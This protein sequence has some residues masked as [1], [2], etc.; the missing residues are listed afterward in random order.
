M[1]HTTNP[2][3]FEAVIF[4]FD[5]TLV[6]SLGLWRAI[7][8]IYLGARGIDCPP[9]LSEAI[10]GMSYTETAEY[11][12]K[13]FDLPDSIDAIKDEWTRLSQDAYLRDIAFKPGAR[14]YLEGL[15]ARDVPVAIAT[16]NQPVTT[17]GFFNARGLGCI[18]AYA[19]SCDAPAGKPA[20]YVFLNAA[21]A[22]GADPKR[23]L[24]FEDT[25]EGVQAARAAG[26]TV[27]AVRDRYSDT[28][29]AQI[30]ALADFSIDDFRPLLAELEADNECTF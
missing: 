24:A 1:Q 15:K 5:G 14:A 26:M 19:Y 28:N 29:R 10:N 4:D 17:E 11:F 13:R 23:C 6:D 22:L 3:A 9:D 21:A 2:H 8:E 27:C 30:E 18:D 20:P 25:L 16:S 12:K 7:D